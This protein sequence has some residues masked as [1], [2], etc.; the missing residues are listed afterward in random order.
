MRHVP[1]E[2]RVSKS[3]VS[4][5]FHNERATV[6]ANDRIRYSTYALSHGGGNGVYPLSFEN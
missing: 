2:R 1:G 3:A 5:Q 6:N 4:K